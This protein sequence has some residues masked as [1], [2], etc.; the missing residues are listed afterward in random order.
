MLDLT[1]M[2]V[3][4]LWRVLADRAVLAA[5]GLEKP[6]DGEDERGRCAPDCGLRYGVGHAMTFQELCDA[7]D[8]ER[9]RENRQKALDPK[10]S[11][12]GILLVRSN[13]G[14]KRRRSR[15]LE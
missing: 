2:V 12:Q 7:D 15:P 1:A 13:A 9:Y 6:C 11:T 10:S 8:G 5:P 14:I 4:R 3:L